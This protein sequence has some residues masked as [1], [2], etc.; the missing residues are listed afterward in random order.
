MSDETHEP[1][2]KEI[3]RCTAIALL[4]KAKN[5]LSYV[6]D[7]LEDRA[8]NLLQATNSVD[9]NRALSLAEKIE[10]LERH[11]ARSC[12]TIDRLRRGQF[13]PAELNELATNLP[14]DDLALALVKARVDVIQR[15]KEQGYVPTGME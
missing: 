10:D 2:P 12:L 4:W 13:T 11:A 14:P 6:D 9:P 5:H 3:H 15:E 7:V 1:M 8:A